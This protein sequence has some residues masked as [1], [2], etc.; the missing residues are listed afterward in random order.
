MKGKSKCKIL[1][2]IRKSIAEE[3]DIALVVSECTYQGECSGTC[4]KCEAEVRYLERELL[5]RQNAGKAVVIAGL[6]AT[7]MASSVACSILPSHTVQGGL[8]PVDEMWEEKGT[9]EIE[10]PLMGDPAPVDETWEGEAVEGEFDTADLL[11]G[12][13]A[14]AEEITEEGTE[15]EADNCEEADGSLGE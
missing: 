7:M 12:E 8:E 10:N 3:N 11:S 13:A 1:K 6:A 5:K 9:F 14:Y 4:P 15:G 2:D